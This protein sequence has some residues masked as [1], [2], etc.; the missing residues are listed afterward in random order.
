MIYDD[1]FPPWDRFQVRILTAICRARRE[2]EKVAHLMCDMELC[3]MLLGLPDPL[4]RL[5][6]IHSP[7]AT[8]V[9]AALDAHETEDMF[10]Y[11]PGAAARVLA[12]M[13][14]RIAI[15]AGIDGP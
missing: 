4:H 2:H 3:E 7:L 1:G 8:E 10:R 12:E 9:R 15:E 5:E 6:E 13:R 11:P 14:I